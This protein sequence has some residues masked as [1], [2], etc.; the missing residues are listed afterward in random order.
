MT[1]HDSNFSFLF[2]L[3]SLLIF[4]FAKLSHTIEIVRNLKLND[5]PEK[6][7]L[8]LGSEVSFKVHFSFDSEV[9]WGGGE[10]CDKIWKIKNLLEN[11]DY[12][13]KKNQSEQIRFSVK[14]YAIIK[15]LELSKIFNFCWRKK[16]FYFTNHRIYPR[17]WKN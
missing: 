3:S 17:E 15:W 5:E 8:N 6:N 14:Q 16:K 9:Y 2:S 4:H 7:K 10:K 1:I 11:I 12:K 13:E